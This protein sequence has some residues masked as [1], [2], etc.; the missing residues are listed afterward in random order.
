MP[1]MDG[2]ELIGKLKERYP[3]M[4]RSSSRAMM[5]SDMRV[6]SMQLGAMDYIVKPIDQRAAGEALDRAAGELSARRRAKR[7]CL[8]M[9][10]S[11]IIRNCFIGGCDKFRPC[12][13]R[14]CRCWW[15][16]HWNAGKLDGE[17]L[18]LLNPLS[19]AWLEMIVEELEKERW[20]SSCR[21]A[22]TWGSGRK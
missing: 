8:L 14:R 3:W 12:S 16:I 11:R 4:R 22:R 19:M 1:V 5:N 15:W 21:K 10:R 13:S 2:L 6:T 18:Y 9:K 20:R 7:R 17:R